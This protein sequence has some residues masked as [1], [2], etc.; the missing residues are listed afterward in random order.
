[1]EDVSRAYRHS[2]NGSSLEG[3]RLQFEVDSVSLRFGGLLA[4]DDVSLSVRQGEIHAIVGPNGAGKTSLL[5]CASGIYRPQQGSIR[6]H[7][8]DGEGRVHELTRAR[9]SRIARWG[10]ARSFQNIELFRHMTVLDN[11][12]LGR[13]VHMRHNLLSASVWFGPARRQEIEQRE[14]VEEVIDFLA[15][16]PFRKQEVA[17]LPY[18]VQK[19]VEL[20]RA[21][22]LCPAILVLDEPMAGMNAEEKEF[23]ARYVLDVNE[24][25]GVTV[26]MIEHDMGVVMDISHRVTVLDFG[27]VIAAG[28]PAEV[29]SDERVIEAYLGEGVRA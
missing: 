29:A 21:L 8:G 20:G 18:G 4:L 16:Q 9:Q 11:L 3:G 2:L 10:V 14:I 13:H 23:M 27:H 17:R 12:L 19:R 15:L 6:L 28:P 24:L 25:A 7:E 22:C 26:V 1:R 5:N